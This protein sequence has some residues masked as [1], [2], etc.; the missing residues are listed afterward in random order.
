MVELEN[1]TLIGIFWFENDENSFSARKFF[2]ASGLRRNGSWGAATFL[3]HE[4]V[5]TSF[6]P[7]NFLSFQI[8]PASCE[9]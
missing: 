3:R 2:N 1:R 8:V 6:L 4:N 5:A 7:P 9:R